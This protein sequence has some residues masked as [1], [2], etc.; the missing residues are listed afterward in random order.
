MAGPRLSHPSDLDLVAVT[1][2]DKDA[3]IAQALL[4]VKSVGVNHG[5]NAEQVKGV[6]R[7][8][9]SDLLLGIEAIRWGLLG[10]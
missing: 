6:R 4:R 5:V 8:V 9:A 10:R 7:V 1:R 3:A 2:V